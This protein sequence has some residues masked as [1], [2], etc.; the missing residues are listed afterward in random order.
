MINYGISSEEPHVI[1][2]ENEETEYYDKTLNQISRKVRILK[3]NIQ[4]VIFFQLLYFFFV[5]GS[6]FRHEK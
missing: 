4:P 3:K 5:L 2:M 6:L 1:I